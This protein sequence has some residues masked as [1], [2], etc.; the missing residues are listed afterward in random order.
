[1]A[2]FNLNGDILE[3]TLPQ[4][5]TMAE[6]NAA[7]KEEI[8]VIASSLYGKDIKINGRCTTALAI[9]LGHELAHI[10]RSVSIFD[11]KENAYV[12]CIKH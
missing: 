6:I 3:V 4:G 11:P 5:C 8:D 9:L 1:M 10:T 7:A 2:M 12:L